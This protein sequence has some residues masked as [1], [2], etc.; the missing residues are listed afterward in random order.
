MDEDIVRAYM[1]E[2]L[3]AASAD[4][5]ELVKMFAE[6]FEDDDSADA[7]AFY[8]SSDSVS[9]GETYIGARFAHFYDPEFRDVDSVK[10]CS[11]ISLEHPSV[12]Y[13]PICA[14]TFL[15]CASCIG[16][17]QKIWYI[18]NPDVCDYCEESSEYFYE[19]SIPV[20]PIII[21][22][23]VCTICVEAHR[24]SMGL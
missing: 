20:G 22:G 2:R 19:V 18:D 17:Y 1:Q 8:S 13:S 14:P 4:A 5:S 23:N 12:M 11:H 16:D 7:D 3:E 21:T 6:Q 15:G 9:F 10:H 24:T